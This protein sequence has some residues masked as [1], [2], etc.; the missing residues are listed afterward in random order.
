MEFVPNIRLL[1]RTVTVLAAIIVVLV[2]IVALRRPRRQHA[3]TEHLDVQ[4][5]RSTRTCASES[6]TASSNKASLRPCAGEGKAAGEET[7]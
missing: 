6:A 5:Q 1:A 7:S 3:A 2:V 4:A